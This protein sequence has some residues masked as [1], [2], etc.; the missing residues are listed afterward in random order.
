SAPYGH[1]P[2]ARGGGP[3]P[4]TIGWHETVDHL[5]AKIGETLT[6]TCAPLGPRDSRGGIWGNQVYTDDS[7]ICTAAQ[8]QG[9]ITEAGGSV[10]VEV[11][12]GHDT[13]L[14]SMR[15]GVESKS[16]GR[17]ERSFQFR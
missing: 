14:G 15:N 1:A 2:T 8:H 3:P 5:D 6:V 11:L 7:S 10:T 12:P 13:Y 4:G 9:L 17:Q 16:Y